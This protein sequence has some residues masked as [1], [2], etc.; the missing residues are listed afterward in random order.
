MWPKLW[1]LEIIFFKTTLGISV[2]TKPKLGSGMEDP[3]RDDLEVNRIVFESREI[4]VYLAL[5]T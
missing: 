1:N 5:N 2:K 4:S 3:S